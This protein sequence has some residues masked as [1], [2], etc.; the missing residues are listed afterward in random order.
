MKK[1]FLAIMAVVLAFSLTAFTPRSTVKAHLVQPSLFWYT[2]S[3]STLVGPLNS[4]A[5]DK[6][7]E[8]TQ[9]TCDDTDVPECLVGTTS[10]DDGG[11]NINIVDAGSDYHIRQKAQ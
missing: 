11:S 10:N 8:M 5:V 6:T 2:L 3:G 4:V 7:T 1:N 9:T